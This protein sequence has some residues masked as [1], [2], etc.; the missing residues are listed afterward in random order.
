MQLGVERIDMADSAAS[1]RECMKKYRYDI[2]LCDIVMPGEDGITFARW[3]LER[4][5]D[6][7]II[8]LTAYAD[9]NYMKEAIAMQSFD[10]VFQPVSLEELRGVVERAIFQIKIEKKTGI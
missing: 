7:K 9:V 10:Y 8:F 5:P 2:F 1:A 6:V 4:D 3:V